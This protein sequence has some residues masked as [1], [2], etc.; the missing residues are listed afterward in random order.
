MSGYLFAF[1]TVLF[2][3]ITPALEK[4]ALRQTD[5]LIAM[6]VRNFSISCI[7]LLLLTGSG[8]LS[9][10]KELD[11]KTTLLIAAGGFLAALAGQWTYFKALQKIDVSR[12][13]PIVG[14]YPLVTLL[15][16][17]LV[18]GEKFTLTKL[19]G[20]LLIVVGIALVK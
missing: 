19:V 8:N 9:K 13:T 12:L 6:A 15:V 14:S 20:T 10:L 5:P 11:A 2:W 1:L 4:G 3:G 16:A 17:T 18:L 7:L